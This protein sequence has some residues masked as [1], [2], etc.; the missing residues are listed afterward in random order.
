[1]RGSFKWQ[2]T[3]GKMNQFVLERVTKLVA[4][5]CILHM[6]LILV[7]ISYDTAF[8]KFLQDPLDQQ[9]YPRQQDLSAYGLC[10]VRFTATVL[11]HLQISLQRPQLD[12]LV[13]E[14]DPPLPLVGRRAEA[15]LKGRG[16]LAEL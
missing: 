14:K 8:Y 10:K 16:D 2:R 15:D 13:R 9:P 12:V 4:W 6:V 1:M 11:R 3:A 7:T 5:Y